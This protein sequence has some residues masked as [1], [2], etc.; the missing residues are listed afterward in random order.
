M[1]KSCDF[2]HPTCIL[3]SMDVCLLVCVC[4][5]ILYI[6]GLIGRV[7]YLFQVPPQQMYWH[8]AG[9]A[10]W[11]TTW[12][13]NQGWRWVR[14]PL[15]TLGVTSAGKMQWSVGRPTDWHHTT[16]C[17]ATLK[18]VYKHIICDSPPTT[19]HR[20]I[21]LLN[22]EIPETFTQ[23]HPE[24]NRVSTAIFWTT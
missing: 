2:I 14:P 21:W 9:G 5:C 8:R 6:I 11:W 15:H 10:G 12:R 22:T 4:A 7:L 13:G 24:D 19:V 1:E 23:S 17:L 18:N 16:C 20:T 3:L